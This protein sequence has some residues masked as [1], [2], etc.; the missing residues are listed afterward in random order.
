MALSCIHIPAM[1]SRMWSAHSADD[2]LIN[3][4]AQIAPCT[5]CSRHLIVAIVAGWTIYTDLDALTIHAEIAALLTGR[6]TYDLAPKGNSRYLI[7]RDIYRIRRREYPVLANHACPSGR[8]PSMEWHIPDKTQKKT[9]LVIP[10]T[11]NER[12]PF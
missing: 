5:D 7:H 6:F 12:V 10:A 3:R 11:A 8:E 4:P 2:H 9:A 1:I